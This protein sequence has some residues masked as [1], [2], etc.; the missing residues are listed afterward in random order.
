MK[1]VSNILTE[2]NDKEIIVDLIEDKINHEILEILLKDR[3]TG[4]NIIWATDIYESYQPSGYSFYDEITLERITGAQNG[5][6]IR[7]RVK[8]SK[9][10]QE[11]RSKDKAE[12]FTAAWICNS[13]NNLIDAA[14]F[15]G[16]SPFNVETEE[17]WIPNYNKIPFPKGKTWQEYVSDIRLEM[18]CGEAPYLVSRFDVTNATKIPVQDRIGLLDRK[19]RVVSENTPD[20]HT[21]YNIEKWRI[22][23]LKALASTYG[24]EWQGDSV[25]LAREAVLQTYIEFYEAKWGQQPKVSALRKIAEIISWNIWQMDGLKYG[26]PGYTPTEQLSSLFTDTQ[27]NERYCRIMDWQSIK[28]L[29][30][31][32]TPFIQLTNK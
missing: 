26:I 21:D 27:P 30:G 12:V 32:E 2:A 4:K 13:Q 23:A 20:E 6:V 7:P 14:W 19:L 3:T 25:L 9:E 24:F 5:M 31:I 28:P 1:A 16:D 11:H 29:N 15:E 22:Y 10:E 18:A 17:G 8:K